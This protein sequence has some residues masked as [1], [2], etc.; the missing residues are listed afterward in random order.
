MMMI[1]K[2]ECDA[3]DVASSSF[4][5]TCRPPPLISVA[6][7]DLVTAVGIAGNILSVV[8]VVIV[9]KWVQVTHKFDFMVFLSFLHFAV[10][11]ASMRVLLRAG[12]FKHK[13][14]SFSGV[15]KIA[16]GSLGSVG[17]MNLN[18]AHNS[19]GF[20]QLSKLACIPVTL[21]LQATVPPDPYARL[22]PRGGGG[23]GRRQRRR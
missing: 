21:F 13:A 11:T 8:G 9:N 18:L 15:Y 10:T 19:V 4:T 14:A 2:I 12:L 1:I 17:F 6:A 22:P 20:Y 23:G 3:V 7:M 16:L 5:D